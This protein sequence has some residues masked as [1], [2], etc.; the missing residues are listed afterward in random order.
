MASMIPFWPTLLISIHQQLVVHVGSVI[1]P[2]SPIVH[3]P[4]F[5][6]ATYLVF[7]C[8]VILAMCGYPAL[9]VC[10]ATVSYHVH[11]MQPG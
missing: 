2:N 4:Y 10:S 3:L 7:L 5:P 1:L 8:C 6:C 11:P 9:G